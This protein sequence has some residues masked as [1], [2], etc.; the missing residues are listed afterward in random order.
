MKRYAVWIFCLIALGSSQMVWAQDRPEPQNPEEALAFAV[1]YGEIQTATTLLGE[2]VSANAR[3]RF[4]VSALENAADSDRADLL[5]LLLENGADVNQTGNFGMTPLMIAAGKGNTR[6]IAALIDAGADVN[7]QGS[8]G[9]TALSL[10]QEG[11]HAAAVN[12][13]KDHGAEENNNKALMSQD[14][15]NNLAQEIEAKS[16]ISGN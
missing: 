8:M 16:T 2:G 5:E 4:G 11:N 3:D 12:L 9:M 15:I 10:S 13:L 1:A 7:V 6:A 14:E